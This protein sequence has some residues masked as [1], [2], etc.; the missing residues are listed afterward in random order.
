MEQEQIVTLTADIVAAHVANNNVAIG[1]IANLIA[2][3]HGALARLQEPPAPA[4]PEKKKGL[5]SVRA[6]VK[7]DHIVCME[8][9]RKQKMLKRHLAT[10][11]GRTP[12]EY[13]SDY[14]LPAS[15]PMVAPAYAERRR[16]LA[17]AIGLGRKPKGGKG[18]GRRSG[19]S[20]KGAAAARNGSA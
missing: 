18:K 14:G 4:E 10:A 16:A 11:H 7:P 2:S 5:V 9:G 19:G 3:V 6:S 8:C 1:D 12:D 20:R 13:R 17:H 15:Y